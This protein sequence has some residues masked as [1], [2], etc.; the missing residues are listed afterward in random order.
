MA[1]RNQSTITMAGRKRTNHLFRVKVTPGKESKV[2]LPP[3]SALEIRN[4]ALSIE[5]GRPSARSVLE[6]DLATHSFVLCALVPNG[7]RQ[8]AL[9]TVITNDPNEPAWLFF[10]ARGPCAFHVLGRLIAEGGAAAAEGRQEEGSDGSDSE[11]SDSEG[12]L[13]EGSE[14]VVDGDGAIRLDDTGWGLGAPVRSSTQRSGSAA[15]IDWEAKD[16]EA[17][18][19]VLLPGD[20]GAVEYPSDADSEQF[21]RWMQGRARE[22]GHDAAAEGS[23]TKGKAAIKQQ[24]QGGGRS[25]RRRA[26]KRRRSKLG[27]GG[28]E[29]GD[30]E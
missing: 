21:V 16:E 1:H 9:A 23:S 17:N 18:I 15:A 13:S 12:G 20:D 26:A 7:P 6:C 28:D 14:E 4:A 24:Q 2:Y 25:A 29:E 22:D 19:E 3:C 10:K 11:G 5:S 8:A 27:E 30:E